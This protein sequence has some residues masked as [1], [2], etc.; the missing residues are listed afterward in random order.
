MPTSRVK[1]KKITT[2]TTTITLLLFS[3]LY[4]SSFL[5]LL[6][7][8]CAHVPTSNF[9]NTESVVAAA[10]LQRRTTRAPPQDRKTFK[11]LC[12][13]VWSVLPDFNLRVTDIRKKKYNFFFLVFKEKL[14]T[15]A[16]TLKRG[17]VHFQRK[18]KP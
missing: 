17:A 13:C 1:E 3:L 6:K 15:H 18:K 8:Q 7:N 4:L 2:A 16:M 10:R 11:G 12:V 5:E 9:F 14:L